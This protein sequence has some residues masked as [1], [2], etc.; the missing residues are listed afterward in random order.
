MNV[1]YKIVT[2]QAYDFT[3]T[4]I[5]DVNWRRYYFDLTHPINGD[6]EK[7]GYPRKA[8]TDIKTSQMP[9]NSLGLIPYIRDSIA[10]GCRIKG[11]IRV[12]GYPDSVDLKARYISNSIIKHSNVSLSYAGSNKYAFD[13]IIPQDTD[14]GSFVGF[15]LEIHKGSTTYRNE[16]WADT[17]EQRNSSH[18]VLWV[19]GTV[20]NDII[21]N[22]SN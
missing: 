12:K 6:G 14:T 8:N 16:K 4:T 3:I 5:Q 13:W 10:A 20:F 17:W 19:K 18:W 2:I 9:I 7:Y 1:N 21:F 22:Q 11:Y 15:D